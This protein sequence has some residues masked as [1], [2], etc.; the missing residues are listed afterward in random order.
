VAESRVGRLGTIDPRGRPHLVPIS[1]V[2]VDDVV[3]SAVDSKPK[4]TRRLQ[5]VSNIEREPRASLLI[6]HYDEDWTKVWWCLIRGRGHVVHEGAEF[7]RAV[8]ALAEK[9]EQYQ[10]KPP[11]G[12]AV[13]L[14]VDEWRGWHSS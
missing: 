3:Y 7:D 12:P 1:F 5:R 2:L 6:D 8:S 13:V 14:E 9:Y 4:T 11:P 10:G